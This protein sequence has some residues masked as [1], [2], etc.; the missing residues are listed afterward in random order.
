MR[1]TV[2]YQEAIEYINGVRWLGSKPGLERV[3]ELLHRL[4]DPQKKLKFVHIAGTN[5]KGSCAAMT[6]SVLRAAGYRTG[7]F[8]SPYLWRFNERMQLNGRPIED[9]ALADVTARLKPHAEAM[10]DHPTEFEMMT[11]AALLWYAEEKCDVV[12]L[13]V[14]LGGRFDATNVIEAPEVSVIMNIGL[15][16]TEIL[17]D[18]LGQIAFE[19]A[20]IV[21]PGCPCVLYEQSE[22]VTEVVRRVCAERKAPLRIADFSA[23]RPEFDSLEGQ[24]FT[25]KNNAYA[26]PLLGAHQMKNAAVVIE[27]VEVLREK[28]WRIEQEALEHGLYAVSW[29][30]RFELLREEPP[31]VVDGGHNVQ[32]AETVADNL[33]R[34]FPD[35]RRVLLM[36]VLRD[37]DVAGMLAVLAP[38]ADAFVCVTPASPR[39]LPAEELA[40]LLRPYGKPVT[41]CGSIPEGVSEALARAEDGAMVCAVG[42]LYMAGEI[43]YCMGMY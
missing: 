21:K 4:G 32:C 37:K 14:G 6:A 36:G 24:V 30:A 3:T 8:T 1:Y 27:A 35:T 9:E 25:Y 15:D 31:F 26:I 18:T 13:E 23:I 12:V 34:Y 29:P 39:A 33:R 20:G 43:R 40:A 22:E 41:A 11:A 17:G 28:G 7:L 16:H 5:G 19:K 2:T 10:A 42:S 38:A